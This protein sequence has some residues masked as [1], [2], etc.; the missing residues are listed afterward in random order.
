VIHGESVTGTEPNFGLTSRSDLNPIF[1][2]F[3]Y[4]DK[5]PL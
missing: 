2:A 1:V 5:D 4:R 3:S